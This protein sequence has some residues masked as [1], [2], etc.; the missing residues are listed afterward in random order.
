MEE[1]SLY[2]GIGLRL[3]L[4]ILGILLYAGWKVREHLANFSFKILWAKNKPFWLWSISM[5]VLLLAVV[6]ISP[7]AAT[8]IKTITGFDITNEPASF[9]LLGH[10]L[11]SIS[12]GAV[13]KKID[14]KTT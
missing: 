3:V 9:L 13:K 11:A 2:F 6:T 12:N 4:G 8:A 1:T 10:G 7:D 5:I 14:K